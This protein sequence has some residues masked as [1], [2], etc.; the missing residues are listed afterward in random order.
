MSTSVVIKNGLQDF[1]ILQQENGYARVRVSGT[2]SLSDPASKIQCISIRV[3]REDSGEAVIPWT[4]CEIYG[5]N[6]WKATLKNIPAGGLY[7]VETA[8]DHSKAQKIRGDM[9]HHIGVGDLFVIAGQSNAAGYGRD[10]ALDPPEIGVHVHKNSGKWDLASHPLS[11]STGSKWVETRE[12]GIPGHSPYLCFA[13]ILKREL[14]YPIGL[15]PTALGGS[16]LSRWNPDED[17]YLYANMLK[18]VKS[19]GGRVKAMLWY[20]GCADAYDNTAVTY[21]R[22]FEGMVNHLRSDLRN[23]ELPVFTVQVNRYLIPA[24]QEKNRGWGILREA[25]RKAAK[26]IPNVFIIPSNDCTL[27]DA[28][29]NSAAANLKLGERLAKS[30]LANVY[31]RNCVSEAPNITKAVKLTGKRIQLWFE[32]VKGKLYT[33]EVGPEKLPFTVADEQGEIGITEYEINNCSGILLVMD[34]EPGQ[35]CVIHGVWEQNPEFFAPI[36]DFSHLP[37]LSFYGVELELPD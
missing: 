32:N 19:A 16:P 4:P 17:G 15:I 26:M 18:R 10:P 14:G 36:D 34:R 27:S 22:R 7:R 3:L 29:H 8:I 20:Q 6:R 1:Q 37:I 23:T 31:R 13:K 28:I 12:I 33:F 9:V 35:N 2:W 25:Q 21:L 11:D 24:S 5:K 30:A